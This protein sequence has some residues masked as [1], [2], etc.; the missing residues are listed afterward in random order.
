MACPANIARAALGAAPGLAELRRSGRASLASPSLRPGN[1]R[2]VAGALLPPSRGSAASRAIRGLA[3][4]PAADSWLG[5][6]A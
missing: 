2:P 5:F 4:R 1:S 6:N 3:S